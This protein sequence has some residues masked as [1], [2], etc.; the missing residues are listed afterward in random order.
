MFNDRV[1]WNPHHVT[2]KLFTRALDPVQNP[3][4]LMEFNYRGP[5]SFSTLYTGTLIDFGVIHSDELIYLF[6]SGIFPLF[7]FNS[8][9][10][11]LI[12]EMVN[13]YTNFVNGR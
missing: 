3:V 9:E 13:I 4:Y 12:T 10:A 2:Y 1:F 8:I 7:D 11:G 5:F 6:D